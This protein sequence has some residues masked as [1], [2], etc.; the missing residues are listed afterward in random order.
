MPAHDPA[1]TAQR[2]T[3]S[4]TAVVFGLYFLILAGWLVYKH[5]QVLGHW[6]FDEAYMIQEFHAGKSGYPSVTIQPV[7]GIAGPVGE[8]PFEETSRSP[9]YALYKAVYWICPRPETLIVLYALLAALSVVALRGLLSQ[10]KLDAPLARW[11]LFCWILYP[12]QMKSAAY[13][14]FLQLSLTGTFYFLYLYWLHKSPASSVLG[15]LALLLPREEPALLILP[16]ILIFPKRWKLLLLHAGCAAAL[17]FLLRAPGRSALAL[18]CDNPWPADWGFTIAFHKQFFSTQTILWVAALTS[19][20]S[21][22]IAEAFLLMVLWAGAPIVFDF[23]FEFVGQSFHYY[24]LFLAPMMAAVCAGIAGARPGRRP[25][26]TA[27][28]AILMVGPGLAY[29]PARVRTVCQAVSSDRAEL[30]R[31]HWFKDAQ[32]APEDAVVTD[33]RL[34]GLFA[35]RDQIYAYPQLPKGVSLD[36]ALARAGVFILDRQDAAFQPA[37]PCWS[38]VMRTPR[39]LFYKKGAVCATTSRRSSSTRRRKVRPPGAGGP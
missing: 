3:R 4:E 1:D 18:L 32:V 13:S 17:L 21:L 35:D 38:L 10:L 34:S 7:S 33:Y 28:A 39:Y 8:R 27:L 5:H 29:L 19:P 24:S 9:I 12:L 15:A 30:R 6:P 16:T 25:W 22:L 14:F 2:W 20:A 23:P 36:Q 37:D 31:I 11:L 26:L